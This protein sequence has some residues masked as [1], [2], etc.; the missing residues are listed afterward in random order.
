MAIRGYMYFNWYMIYFLTVI[1][2]RG[3]IF[4][5]WCI[6]C[7]VYI[8]YLLECLTS[9]EIYLVLLRPVEF[10]RSSPHRIFYNC[11]CSFLFLPVHLFLQCLLQFRFNLSQLFFTSILSCF[12]FLFLQTITRFSEDNDLESQRN[13]I[14]RVTH[15][16]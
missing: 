11:P 2:K 9:R 6:Q 14:S 10:P 13:P 3:N 4:F 7:D 16:G 12:F 8:P 5:S 15:W 1:L